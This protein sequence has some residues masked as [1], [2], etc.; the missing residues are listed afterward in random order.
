MVPLRGR[1]RICSP[2]IPSADLS[3]KPLQLAACRYRRTGRILPRWAT[4]SRE[5]IYGASIR[6][7]A[8]RAKQARKEADRLS[9]V[10]WNQR[11]LGYRGPAQPSPALGDALR[12]GYMYLE[13]R[14]LGCDTHQTV[15][16]NIIRRPK[17]T[18]VHELE[19][20]MRCKD[21]SQVRGYPY[22]RSHLVA[23]RQ[24]K[25]SANDPPSTWWPG[26]R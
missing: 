25:I 6:A 22:K 3:L 2:Q 13:V 23:L 17:A 7:S 21:C 11:M 5:T 4:K 16:L 10:A 18:P 1:L 12:A 14:C 19:R 24:T 20:Y 26:E 9:C 8:E 15:A